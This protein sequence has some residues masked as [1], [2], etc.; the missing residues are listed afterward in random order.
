M[1]CLNQIV[2]SPEDGPLVAK[3]MDIYFTCFKVY[4]PPPPLSVPIGLLTH[5]L[6]HSPTHG[7]DRDVLALLCCLFDLACFFIYSY[8]Y[9]YMYMYMMYV[10]VYCTTGV[11]QAE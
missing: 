8:L 3:L 1:C 10:Y 9:M 2:L 4:T 5:S 7:R 6:T 11:H